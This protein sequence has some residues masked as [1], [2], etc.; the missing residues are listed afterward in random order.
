TDIYPQE[1]ESESSEDTTTDEESEDIV[2]I[3]EELHEWVKNRKSMLPRYH[4]GIGHIPGNIL[5]VETIDKAKSFI[6]RMGEQHGESIAV[7]KYTQKK[8]S[9]QITV[10]Y[11][12]D[13]ITLLPS[14]YLYS[15]LHIAYNLMHPN[16]YIK[17]LPHDP[18]QSEKWYYLSLL[19]IYQFGFV[20]EGIDKHW[21]AIYTEVDCGFG[22]TKKEYSR[23]EIW[24]IDQ[25]AEV[26]E[27]SSPN[28]ISAKVRATDPW[29]EFKLIKQYVDINQLN[30]R[31]LPQ[32]GLLAEKQVDL[33]KN[34]GPYCPIAF[35]NKLCSKLPDSVIERVEHLKGA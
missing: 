18:Q 29:D 2:Q 33:W 11:E 4:G 31:I 8:T 9:E 12:K 1:S 3:P 26:I 23:L 16:K 35:R 5:S 17:K 20:D 22:S 34:I 14:H 28:N 21:H 13:D 25:L 27:R 10:T 6:K 32:K 7:R 19:K 15:R 24:Y 30:P